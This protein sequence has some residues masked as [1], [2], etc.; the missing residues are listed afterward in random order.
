[1]ERG[2]GCVQ[3]VLGVKNAN[4]LGRTLTHEH[5]VMAFETFYVEPRD[6]LK[7][8]FNEKIELQNLG[9]LRQYPYSSLYNLT[10]ND[11]DSMIAV[12]ED[13]KFFSEFGGGTIV[14]NSNHGLKRDISLMKKLSKDSGVT[15][16]AGT[17]YYVAAT[18]TASNLGL[19]KEE[20]YNVMLKEMTIGCDESPDVKTGFIGEVGSTWPIEDFEKRAILATGELQGQLKCPVSFHPGRDAAAPF[21]I[22]RL[23][24]EAGGDA[25]KAILSHLDRTLTDEQVLLEFADENKCYCQFDLFG[26][27]CSFYQLNPLVDMQSDA[28]RIDRVKC[29]RDDKKLNRILLSH[30]IHTK[31]RLMKFG[32]HGF[33][34]IMNNVLPKMKLKG[35]T[36]EEIDTLT[37]HNPRTWL[38]S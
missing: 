12:L 3:T 1:M 2:S 5:L 20:M 23:Y 35:L 7:R 9:V 22:M 10:L 28:Q 16:I 34:H 24:Q 4:E 36:Q 30:D 8:F 33:S 26:T 38:S 21:E 17:G 18:Q 32:G 25:R 37:I 13:I 19:S 31:H 6:H 27:E 29:L 15:I 11:K 14:E